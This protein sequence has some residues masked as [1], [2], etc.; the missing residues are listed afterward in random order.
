MDPMT[1][2]SRRFETQLEG[3]I[4]FG[5]EVIDEY[6]MKAVVVRDPY[7]VGTASELFASIY[8][9]RRLMGLSSKPV[10]KLRKTGKSYAKEL[11]KIFEG[12]KEEVKKND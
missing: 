7:P 1:F 12:L 10:S 3:P 11:N 8:Y 9:G 4:K 5:D 2:L 6:E